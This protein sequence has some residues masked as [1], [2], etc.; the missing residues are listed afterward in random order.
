[1]DLQRV[2]N[3][4]CLIAGIAVVLLGILVR[5]GM[6]STVEPGRSMTMFVLGGIIA[7]WSFLSLRRHR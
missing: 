2:V 3:I 4:I 5:A 1:M 6:I 7:I